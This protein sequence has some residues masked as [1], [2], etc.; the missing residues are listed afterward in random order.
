M[1]SDDEAARR[2]LRE[3]L[4]VN[5]FVEAAAGTGKTQELVGRAVAL[6]AAGIAQVDRLAIITFTEKAAGELKLRLRE[7]L[8]AA[9]KT[10]EN[11]ARIE[12]A[13]AHL[14]EASIDTIHGFCRE[15]LR[16]RPIQAGID[17]Q[18]RI[19]ADAQPWIRRAFAPWF[20]E[21]L[22]APPEG[23][24][25][26]LARGRV[27]GVDETPTT[28]LEAAVRDLLERRELDA[29]WSRPTEDLQAKAL[30]L[31][32][33]VRGLAADV[34]RGDENDK[35]RLLLTPLND[36]L[37]WAGE[38]TNPHSQD[39]SL[40]SSEL[41]A[42]L[43]ALSKTLGSLFQQRRTDRSSER[44]GYGPYAE[45]LTRPR[46]IHLARQL[47]DDLKAYVTLADQDLAAVLRE[48]LRA[49]EERYVRL[50]RQ[51]GRLD[52]QDL[53][54]LTRDLLRDNPMVRAALQDRFRHLMVDELQDTD[55]LQA[56]IILLLA[57]EDLPNGTSR[58]LSGRLTLVG[59]PRQSIYG[60]RRA[61]LRAYARLRRSLQ[62]QGA[63]LLSLGV[64]HRSVAPIQAFVNR[65]FG[66]RFGEGN[67]TDESPGY[68]PLR[69]GE[70][71]L[72]EQPSVIALPA[73]Q[74]IGDY[75]SVYAGAIQRDLPE[76]VGA[77]VAW[78]VLESGWQVR[79]GGKLRP[80]ESSDIC[81][82]FRRIQ[83]MGQLQTTPFEEALEARGLETILMGARALH[84]REEIDALILVLQALEWPED[85]LAVYGT[86]RGPFF[87]FKDEALFLYRGARGRLH[88]FRRPPDAPTEL[89]QEI[90]EA[91]DILRTL[92]VGRNRRPFADTVQSL[93]RAT[94]A[95]VGLGLRPGGARVLANVERA[96]DLAR[97]HES[98]GGLSFRSFVQ[99]FRAE[100]DRA[101]T[102]E[103]VI[104]EEDAPGVRMM[105]V[106][107]A[108]GLEF[109]IVVLA[110]PWVPVWTR[111]SR[112]IEPEQGLAALSLAGLLPKDVADHQSEGEE[113]ERKESLRLAYVAATRAKDLLVVPSVGADAQR[114]ARGT[115]WLEPV[116]AAVQPNPDQLDMV[117]P[118]RG[119]PPFGSYT[120]GV[121]PG[122][123]PPLKVLQPGS[124]PGS[125]YS[126]VWWD[127]N[128]LP[129]RP[130]AR[131]G[132]AHEQFLAPG[133]ESEQARAAHER[134]RSSQED[135]RSLGMEQSI[136]LR[137]PGIPRRDFDRFPVLQRSLAGAESRPSGRRYG[138]LVHRVLRD[139][140][141]G[142]SIE[143]AKAL[144]DTYA[145]SLEAP[146]SEREAVVRAVVLLLDDDLTQRAL[147]SAVCR[148]GY[149]ILATER[150]G[151]VLDTQVD[152]LFQEDSGWVA[153]D[154]VT[155]P[156]E[157][158]ALRA[159]MG[160]VLAALERARYAV[161]AGIVLRV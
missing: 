141:F 25:R 19:E 139:L 58:L 104:N 127:P 107:K 48:E 5:L 123:R 67:G 54:V 143:T 26:Y 47:T 23:L 113:L 130:P 53:L 73:R 64:S 76:T 40:D 132:I 149:P 157:A 9:R 111:P 34:D 158:A 92:S 118:A 70:V 69:G 90:Q 114:I 52:F 124:Y 80:V 82:L 159:K 102:S 56:E 50:L 6:L 81:L 62:E 13:I 94:R 160:H 39:S 46:L 29:P 125:G 11:A 24:R 20:A 59:D 99:T 83:R 142:A 134:W 87:G 32:E 101:R 152:L 137:D 63:R 136:L 71:A 146:E 38:A 22:S 28:K 12:N 95:H 135:T 66:A 128:V 61:D 129:A 72:P 16:S 110:D 21:N 3:D 30:A 151:S 103:G 115:S 156:P 89:E 79:D 119:C 93:L 106:H 120:V 144:T 4:D 131:Y 108:K 15:I 88:P 57:T 77:F 126:P 153:V 27:S 117:L 86:L 121:A 138:Q 154:F 41:E 150:D 91:L 44:F 55:P 78:V 33:R 161:A 37:E 2:A 74:P 147:R 8:E 85:E 43:V 97:R 42:W 7:A 105:T 116:L 49:V 51:A 140:D 112:F 45:G 17:P 68:I 36:L 148:R 75:G 1:Q 65:A 109:P 60:F 18:F 155:A 98:G 14:E 10:G 145:R 84:D 35:L 122:Q 96:L 133:P 31:L 100:A